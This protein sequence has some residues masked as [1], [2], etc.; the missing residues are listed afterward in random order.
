LLLLLLL[1]LPPLSP[2]RRHL[3]ACASISATALWVY[4]YAE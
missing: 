4:R 3:R 1:L 2:P